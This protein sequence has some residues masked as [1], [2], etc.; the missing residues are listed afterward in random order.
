MKKI[1]FLLG[2]SLALGISAETTAQ[3]VSGNAYMKGNLVEIG[4]DG[5]WG[6]EGVD[7][8]TSPPLGGMHYRSGTQYFG[9]VANPQVNLWTTFDGDFFTPGSP[10]NG[11]GFECID[12][13]GT[14]VKASNNRVGQFEI[15][16][17]PGFSW[18]TV[19]SCI[20]VDHYSN[21]TGSGYDLDFHINYYLDVN[22]LF[23][24]TTVTVTNSS[25]TTVNDFYYY[26][27][28]DPDN[29]QSIGFDFTTTNE[30]VSQPGS[31]CNKA[32]VRAT[33]LVPAS[34][35]MSYVGMAGVGANFRVSYGGFSNRDGSDIWNGTGVCIGTTG[36][37]SFMDE[38]ISLAYRI[39]NLAPGASETFKFVIILDD[40]AANNAI[41]N[42]F[43]FDYTGSLGGP[44]PACFPDIDTVETCS[45]MPV[46]ISVN[47]SAVSDFNWTWSPATGLSTTTGTSTMAGPTTTTTYT[48]TG[49]PINPCFSPVTKDIV[50]TTTNG[51]DASYTDPG[52]QCGTFDLSTLAIADLNSVAGAEVGFYTVVPATLADTASN[53]FVGTTLTS[54][55]VVYVVYYDPVLGC[56]NSELIDLTWGSVSATVDVIHPTCGAADGQITVNVAT[57]GTYN[58]T[59]NGGAPVTTNVF[60]GLTAGAY[61]I[62]VDDG[63]G[64]NFTIDTTLI[65]A[66]GPS[67]TSINGVDPSC[68]GLTDGSITVN[69]ASG[70]APLSFQLNGGTGQASNVFNGVGVGVYTITVTDAAGCSASG[71]ISLAQPPQITLNL[72]A[73]PAVVCIGQTSTLNAIAGGG[74]GAITVNWAAPIGSSGTSATVDPAM[75]GINTYT[76]TATDASG[77]AVTQTVTVTENPA[78]TVQTLADV[79]VCPG[80]SATLGI[81]SASGG[82]GG[83]YTF[84]WSNNI[85]GS[86]LIGGSQT[87]LPPA[88]PTI[89]TVTMTDGCGTPAVTE[90]QTVTVYAVPT[91]DFS[92][93][94]LMDC[95]PL[96]TNFTNLTDPS[97][98]A[99]CEW[100]FE[101]GGTSMN[102]DNQYIWSIPGTY[103]VTL[104]VTT[105][106]GC[107]VDT[108]FVNYITVNPT[109]VPDFT[110]NPNPAN[111][112]YPE[113]NFTNLTLGGD[114]YVWDIA[115][116]QTTSTT[117]PSFEFSDDTGAVYQVCLYATN[118]FNCAASICH[119]VEVQSV[120][121]VYAPN[122]F[123]PNGDGVNDIFLPI[124]QGHEV[125]SYEMTIFNRWGEVVFRSN[126]L[127]PGW[128]GT[129]KNIKAKE[130]TYVWK[131]KIKDDR[132]AKKVEYSGHVNLLR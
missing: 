63:S 112:L 30:V 16:T 121:L 125:N 128:D 105:T 98:T 32:H 39:Q 67:I 4:I 21:Y 12:A 80:F 51:P 54:S 33:S 10:E 113:V 56:I 115:G 70:T 41:N 101:D 78:L 118:M 58:Y 42:L 93:D 46:N 102:C 47:G 45:G 31:G 90:T 91:P 5:Q 37:T 9:F 127:T 96:I 114:S 25:P 23:Y 50:V 82:N 34:Q 13:G 73:T 126:S 49:T 65:S 68:F 81:A 106:D 103:D 94:N 6:F 3:I 57:P 83:P 72:T 59:L 24:T 48:V 27:N 61:T 97:M 116:L 11:W 44:P 43:Y 89:Y 28:F 95:S 104:T 132:N 53:H 77:C 74:S 66:G 124:F 2:I 99:N 22:D 18:Q 71:N 17:A 55:D 20:I 84:V 69:T 92:G 119:E 123:T 15:A 76:A 85:N 7:T 8:F 117:H 14:S 129:H 131:I 120:L 19:G 108:T 79:N 38:A 110:W 1:K 107:I 75:T 52:P 88:N 130:D 86:T 109:P 40:A 111:V 62:T 29:N 26:R 60:G 36:T 100:L 64:C 35:P 87:V 122:T